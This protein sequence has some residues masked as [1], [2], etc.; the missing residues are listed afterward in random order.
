MKYVAYI[1]T[2]DI[3]NLRF[4]EDA[5]GKYL[6]VKDANSGS[7]E[8]IALHFKEVSPDRDITNRK[9]E[10]LFERVENIEKQMKED[11]EAQLRKLTA[12]IDY[13]KFRCTLPAIPNIPNIRR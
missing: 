9:I 8:W 10:E 3:E 7:D 11:K 4:Y 6:I 12:E 2:D 5:D 1:D 13:A